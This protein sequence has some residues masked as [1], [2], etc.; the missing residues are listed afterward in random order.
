MGLRNLQKALLLALLT[1]HDE[2][3]NLQDADNWTEL[4]IRQEE[5]KILPFGAVWAE[6]CDR[7]GV[8][9]DGA[10]YATVKEYEDTVM[11]KR[12]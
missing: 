7:C 2:L 9:Q 10:W 5:H 3:K 1:P 11:S 6:Y 12:G 8:P 4:M